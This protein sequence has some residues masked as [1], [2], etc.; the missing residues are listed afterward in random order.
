MVRGQ[1]NRCF[2]AVVGVF[3]VLLGLGITFDTL[4]LT[5]AR[6]TIGRMAV[7]FRSLNSAIALTTIQKQFESSLNLTTWGIVNNP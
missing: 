5:L 6:L 7:T 3:F 2:R 1:W 4:V